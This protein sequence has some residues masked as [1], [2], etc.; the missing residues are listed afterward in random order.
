MKKALCLLTAMVM[1]LCACG[2]ALAETGYLLLKEDISEYLGAEPTEYPYYLD[3]GEM[4][5]SVIVDIPA[6]EITV[7]GRNEQDEPKS[8][9]WTTDD[10]EVI[11]S[12]FID[13]CSAYD[14]ITA[15]LDEGW[16]LSL[17][18]FLD[19]ETGIYIDSSE[20]AE[21]FVEAMQRE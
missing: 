20:M 12:L 3:L 21:L 4:E 9:T 8:S 10:P 13:Y 14:E 2:S 17:A 19:E 7:Y 6:V 15:Q 18:L 16:W 5:L 1:L 11:F